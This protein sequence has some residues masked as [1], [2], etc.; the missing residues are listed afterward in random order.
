M[1]CLRMKC[2]RAVADCGGDGGPCARS[3]TNGVG[4]CGGI[5]TKG[6]FGREVENLLR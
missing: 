3:L 2:G 5:L 4:S 1:P 6:Y